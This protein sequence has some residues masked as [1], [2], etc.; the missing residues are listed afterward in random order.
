MEQKGDKITNKV[1]RE[2]IIAQAEAYSQANRAGRSEIIDGLESTLGR[3]RKSLIRSL[4]TTIRQAQKL[5]THSNRTGVRQAARG[6]PRRYTKEVEAALTEVWEVYNCICAERLYP[7]ISSAITILQ[8]DRDWHYSTHATELL[9]QMPMGTMKNYLVRIAKDKGLMRGIST[10]RSSK[11]LE[12]IPIF[13]GDWKKKPVGY[14]Q[15]DTVVHS[16]PR[17]EG[18]MAYTVNFIEMQTY[19][20]E[21]RAQLNKT[22]DT[23]K[24]TIAH[25]IRRTPFIVRGIHSDTGDEFVNYLLLGWCKRRHIEFTRSRPY[26][27]ND[28]CNVEERNRSVIRHYVGYERYDCQEAVDVMNELYDALRLYVNFFQPIMKLKEKRRYPNGNSYRKY[29]LA[30]TPYERVLA[31]NTIPEATKQ[32][33]R[34]QYATLNPKRLLATIQALTIKL[35]RIQKEQGYHF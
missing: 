23:T 8:R 16:G 1:A 32:T 15:I 35:E 7:Q 19:W 14:G 3:S 10:T 5:H 34:N 22:D 4:N 13:H 6:R 28:N 11:L 30:K 9:L 24:N 17:L 26:E 25:L 29:E 2:I 27:K 21:F 12:Q 18:M 33:L 20:Q 31:H